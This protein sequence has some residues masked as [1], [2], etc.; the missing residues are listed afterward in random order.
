V[1]V[2]DIYQHRQ[3]G[4]IAAALA[5]A[6]GAAPRRPTGRRRPPGA[7]ACGAGPAAA[8][9]VAGHAAHGA[10]AGAVLHL[11]LLHRR[12]GRLGARAIAASIG[13]FLLA[14]VM[15]FVI[16]IAGKWLIAGRLRPA[17]IRCGA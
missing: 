15:E 8:V 5:E 4:K 1:T 3:V 11:S 2:R 10:M 14:T 13:V 12:T 9:P 7:L 16:A 6:P 17:S